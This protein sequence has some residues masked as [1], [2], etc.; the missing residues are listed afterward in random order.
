MLPRLALIAMIALPLPWGHGTMKTVR[1]RVAGWTL[2][3]RKDSFSGRTLCRLS[4]GHAAYSRGAL[5]LRL[6]AR[7]NSAGAVYR[8]DGGPA[9][10]AED[11]EMEIARLGFALHDDSLANPSGGL[12]RIP[13]RRV[14]QARTVSIQA[15]PGRQPAVFRI[16]GLAEALAAGQAAG[17]RTGDFE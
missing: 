2:T 3:V 14:L 10:R 12:V 16:S 15:V 7:V 8:V 4:R 17:C 6:S 5:T 1:R 9:L 11:D 13:E